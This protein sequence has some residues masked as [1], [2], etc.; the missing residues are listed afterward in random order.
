MAGAAKGAISGGTKKKGSNKNTK[1]TTKVT[2]K[3]T[4]KT[5]TKNSSSG[6][7]VS[8]NKPSA[9]ANYKAASYSPAKYANG[10]T[11][12]K[13]TSEYTQRLSNA[14]N[15]V[16]NWQ[17]DPLKD[18]SYQSLAKV[19]NAQGNIAAKNS[20]ADAAAL[21]GGMSTSYAVSAAQQARN[22]Y[23]Q[24]L[25]AMVPELENAAYN[26]ATGTLSALREADDTAYGRFRDTE[27]DKQWLE[28]HK[29]DIWG[30]NEQSR[31]WARGMNQDERQFRYTAN[32][33]KYRDLM[34]DYQWGMNYN[35][36]IGRDKVADTQWTKEFELSKK[37]S[38]SGGGRSGGGGGGRSGGGGY[39]GYSG[40]GTST[41]IGGATVK[42]GA[43]MDALSHAIADG[44]VTIGHGGKTKGT[45]S[46][47]GSSGTTKKKKTSSG[48]SDAVYQKMYGRPKPKKK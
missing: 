18:A 37:G 7:K 25:A 2:K 22:Q 14:L 8:V 17:Y 36:Q 27:A 26:R 44:K 45:S 11:P 41:T 46:S 3:V 5:T 35:Y 4:K 34:S 47:S 40:S 42:P 38:S 31:Q 39:S 30:A 28:G 24:Q 6:S 23:N 32:Y 13:Y 9:P 1:T 10:Y 33:N 20:L 21:N 29:F 12:G 15:D 48:M 19:Y 43:G 16:T